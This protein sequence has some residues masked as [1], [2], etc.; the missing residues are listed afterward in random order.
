MRREVFFPVFFLLVVFVLSS[1]GTFGQE[2]KPMVRGL[3]AKSAPNGPPSLEAN[4]KASN[5]DGLLPLQ[6]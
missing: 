6:S 2:S 1:T 4:A 3:P 5:R